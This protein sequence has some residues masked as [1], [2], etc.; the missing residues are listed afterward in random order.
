MSQKTP[1]LLSLI[2]TALLFTI[3]CDNGEKEVALLEKE[4]LDV[5]DEVMPLMGPRA[6]IDLL[7][8]SLQDSLAVYIADSTVDHSD[9]IATFQEAIDGLESANESMM[10]WMREYEPGIGDGQS[11]EERLTYLK[12]ELVKVND[13]KALTLSSIEAA[14]SL[15]Q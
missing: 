13:M 2:F 1:F 9:K 5:H 6:E 11:M 7:V 8:T 10:T 12:D 3:S 15:I 4:V 14:K